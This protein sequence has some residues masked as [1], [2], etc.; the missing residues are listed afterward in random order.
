MPARLDHTSPGA[1]RFA[2]R[3]EYQRALRGQL[4]TEQKFFAQSLVAHNQAH[5]TVRHEALRK[6]LPAMKRLRDLVGAH[7][8]LVE[9]QLPRPRLV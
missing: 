3:L 4:P 7:H 8:H 9:R 6:L 5:N 2:G 1:R